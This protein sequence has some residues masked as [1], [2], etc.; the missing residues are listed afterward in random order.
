M[1]AIPSVAPEIPARRLKY[2]NDF[3]R[4]LLRLMQVD[5][6]FCGRCCR[7]LSPDAFG[8][9][10]FRWIFA[11]MR[12]F[13]EKYQEPPTPT[14][15]HHEAGKMEPKI[16]FRYRS[17]IT[18]LATWSTLNSEWVRD[19][20][21]EFCKRAYFVAKHQEISDAF[22][23]GN[24]EESYHAMSQA[25][26]HLGGISFRGTEDSWFFDDF[27]KRMAR[28]TFKRENMANYS[29]PTGIPT[30]DWILEGGVNPPE[31]ALILADSKVGKTNWLTHCGAMATRAFKRV[32]HFQ[33]EDT[34]ETAEARYDASL[35]FG[36]VYSR[37][38]RGLVPE[39]ELPRISAYYRARKDCLK[40]VEC[41]EF[42]IDILAL[43]AEI[44][45]LKATGWSPDLIVVDYSDLGRARPGVRAD[46]ETAHQTAFI[47]DLVV[48]LRKHK[49]AG[50]TASQ[51]QRLKDEKANN[52]DF[53]V[54]AKLIADAYN[55]VRAAH[56]ICSLNATKDEMARKERRL[57]AELYRESDRAGRVIVLDQRGIATFEERSQA[58]PMAAG[59]VTL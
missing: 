7:H 36:A 13:Y 17:A 1:V 39:E 5:T 12:D 44:E 47:K 23:A 4:T 52:P 57:Y 27:D 48:L 56:F 50:W 38:K 21:E 54:S 34:K 55:K 15:L 10:V 28:R 2:D 43:Q 32:L 33:L 53:V 3:L 41:N 16:A 40:V 22:N 24:V 9:E 19:E 8:D 42:S 29:C 59:M 18:L 31:L 26:E 25:S 20:L 37:I 6:G 49:A 11:K 14:V 45:Q 51:S 30:L 35:A 46:S 58:Q